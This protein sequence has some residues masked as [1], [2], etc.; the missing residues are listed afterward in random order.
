MILLKFLNAVFTAFV[1]LACFTDT[2]ISQVNSEYDEALADSLG[3]DE[4]GMKKYVLAILKAGPSETKDEDVINKAFRGHMENI[5]RL[6]NEGKLIV[7]GP[8]GENSKSYRGIYIF[9]V[10][11][12]PE[13]EELVKTDPAVM[14]GLLDAELYEWY[15]SAALGVYLD[16]HT[17]ISKAKP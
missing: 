16:T 8:L 13:A 9:N 4:Y 2:V 11:T 6:A 1:L 7:A 5:Q 14:E 17:K 15:G 10:K 12:I 3:A